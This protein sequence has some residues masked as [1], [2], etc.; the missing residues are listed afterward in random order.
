M[1][2]LPACIGLAFRNALDTGDSPH[3]VVTGWI[4][5]TLVMTIQTIDQDSFSIAASARG[6]G[7]PLLLIAGLGGRAAFW[8]AQVPGLAQTHRVILHDHRGT[9][10]STRWLGTYSI[11]Q[12]AA[13]VLSVMDHFG[14]ERAHMV[15][16]STGGAIV[17]HLACHTPERV[18]RI[19]LS[20][21]WPGPHPY[22]SAL[23]DLRRQVL[24][25]LGPEAYLLDGQVRGFP[26]RSLV[27]MA[28]DIA[29]NRAARLAAFPGQEIELARISA[30]LDHD[31]RTDLSRITAPTMVICAT[32]D[33]ITPLPFSQELARA[34]PGARLEILPWG[35]H[36]APQANPVAYL[37]PVVAFLHEETVG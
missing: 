17:Q 36:F 29:A 27:D 8:D 25:S 33:Q 30:I 15:G 22:F 9:G 18:D 7:P 11:A 31:A 20:A 1:L 24:E 37:R 13:D 32:D 28:Q 3:A 10:A 23:F 35:G 21:S 14:V 19:V 2:L 5:V 12:M 26:A 6:E 4:R 16:H 34:I